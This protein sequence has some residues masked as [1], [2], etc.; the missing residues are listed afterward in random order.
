MARKRGFR[1]I[2]KEFKTYFGDG[3]LDDWQRLCRDVGLNG[4][5]SSIT[6]CRKALR[7]VHVNIFDL[8]DAVKEGRTPP[9][10]GTAGELAEYTLETGRVYPKKAAK[11][12]GPVRALLRMI[13]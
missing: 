4:E 5:Y 1:N 2:V 10:F 7:T 12:M 3:L 6:Q 8:L 13:F 9:H 11:K